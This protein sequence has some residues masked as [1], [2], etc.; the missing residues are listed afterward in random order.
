VHGKSIHSG[1]G[2]CG[3]AVLTRSRVIVEDIRNAPSWVEYR[4]LAL[5]ARLGSC[6]S[7][8]IYSAGGSV[9]G[10]FAI[11]HQRCTAAQHGQYRPD[12]PGC[13]PGRHRHR[14]GAGGGGAA[15]RRGPVPQP[16]RP[17]AGGSVG[18]GLVGRCAPHLPN[19]NCPASTI[20]P[21]YLQANPSQLR[22]LASLVRILDVN[23]AALEQVGA[24]VGGKDLS[25]LT[26]AQNFDASAMSRISRW[27]WRRWRRVVT[28]LP[29]KA[30]SSG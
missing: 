7:D 3:Q 17:R 11:Y 20:W 8:P 13:A 28:S 22:R 23:A 16:V 27:R 1:L 9:L 25:A 15:R 14:A 6:W 4:D 29:V 2:A 5:Q 18:A 10:T 12:R 19:W 24:P 26:L 30:V 21:L